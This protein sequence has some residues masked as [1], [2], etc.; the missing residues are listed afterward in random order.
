MFRLYFKCSTI[1]CYRVGI[2]A[3]GL[4][5]L[6]ASQLCDNPDTAGIPSVSST[7]VTDNA[8]YGLFLNLQSPVT[9]TGKITEFDYT[10][11]KESGNNNAEFMIQ[12][13]LWRPGEGGIYTKVCQWDFHYCSV[14]PWLYTYCNRHFP[15]CSISLTLKTL[16]ICL[17]GFPY[18]EVLAF[19]V[20][21][22]CQHW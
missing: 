11:Y 5:T 9:C 1:R 16:C 8:Q 20:A 15:L 6:A 4:L 7:P 17:S 18:M 3:V 19:H 21:Y 13:S 14:K 12:L 22:K 2:F 10:F